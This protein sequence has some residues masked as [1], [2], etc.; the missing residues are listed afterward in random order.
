M[1]R[2]R[3]ALPNL[4]HDLYVDGFSHMDFTWGVHA[5]SKVYAPLMQHMKEAYKGATRA[6]T[7][8]ASVATA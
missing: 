5:N 3:S 2:I 4:Q 8:S 7:P 1:Q 6:S